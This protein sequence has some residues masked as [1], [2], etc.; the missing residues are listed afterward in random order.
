MLSVLGFLATDV[1]PARVCRHTGGLQTPAAAVSASLSHIF[2][3]LCRRATT[4]G[5]AI[6]IVMA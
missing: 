2:S 1:M 4:L 5:T 3:W 6:R